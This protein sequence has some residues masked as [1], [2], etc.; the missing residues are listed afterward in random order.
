MQLSVRNTA[1]KAM[2]MKNTVSVQELANNIVDYV[3][4]PDIHPYI[5]NI[6]SRA[7]ENAV[8]FANQYREMGDIESAVDYEK[9]AKIIKKRFHV[10]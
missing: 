4:N 9:A 2:A 8:A 7:I 5:N 3:S 1:R 6:A 10:K